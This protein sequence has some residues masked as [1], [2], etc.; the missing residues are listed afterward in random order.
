VDERF[1]LVGGDQ[2]TRSAIEQTLAKHGGT[3]AS[4]T[5]EEARQLLAESWHWDGLLICVEGTPGEPLEMLEEARHK[6]C[7]VPAMVLATPGENGEEIFRRAQKLQALYLQT[8]ADAESIEAFAAFANRTS[9]TE[10]VRMERIIQSMRSS[11]RL[12]DR[13]TEILR[14][15]ATGIPRAQLRRWLP[16]KETS[17]KTHVRRLLRKVGRKSIGE[18]VA[19]IHRAV[20]HAGRPTPYRDS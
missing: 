8:P 2:D 3:R 16:I 17:I 9:A 1:L 5:V 13:E 12:T 14:L 20:F 6:G 18:L 10:G 19:T 11:Y 7:P 15:V 4:A